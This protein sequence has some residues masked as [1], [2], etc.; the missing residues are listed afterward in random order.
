MNMRIVH[1]LLGLALCAACAG[2]TNHDAKGSI[3]EIRRL[4]EIIL[5]AHRSGDIDS[6]LT[7]EADSFVVVNRGE[8]TFPT[9]A[10]RRDMLQP[11]LSETEFAVYRDLRE[12]IVTI[13]TD[14]SQG[15]LIAQVEARGV[16]LRA[17][18]VEE[19][20]VFVAAWIELY[21]RKDG[22]WLSVGNVSNFRPQQ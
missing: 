11:Y 7:V 22:R 2:S 1:C 12:P 6:W 17:D 3:A 5:E 18:D 19:P 14:G 21:Q 15:W 10:E 4:H 13:S 8:V 20:I 9:K 16:R